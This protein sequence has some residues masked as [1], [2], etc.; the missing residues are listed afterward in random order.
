MGYPYLNIPEHLA[1]VGFTIKPWEQDQGE[2]YCGAGGTSLHCVENG[3][4]AWDAGDALY[5]QDGCWAIYNALVPFA[6][7]GTLREL[8]WHDI[9][10]KAGRRVPSTAALTW[11]HRNHVHSALEPGRWLPIIVAPPKRH[12]EE[13]QTLASSLIDLEALP[14]PPE[15]PPEP[16]PEPPPEPEPEPPP[17][18]EPE[19][20]PV[21]PPVPAEG[22]DLPMPAIFNQGF[23]H[24][25]A[26]GPDG[27]LYERW[28]NPPGERAVIPG[29]EG[30]FK[31]NA[32]L[33]N[34]ARIVY[35]PENLYYP[36]Y[37]FSGPAA[38]DGFPIIV[39]WTGDHWEVH[40]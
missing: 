22:D 16:Q 39:L 20:E 37:F 10:W 4:Y 31:P 33:S 36:A 14:V 29:T 17:E 26:V 35:D 34:P 24:G 1:S 6:M 3:A 21:P 32:P 28:G 19:P 25:F 8:I 40:R 13:E 7:D 12:Y 5:G 15:P 27:T 2:R 9:F 38:A 23:F 30:A 18:P 11:Q